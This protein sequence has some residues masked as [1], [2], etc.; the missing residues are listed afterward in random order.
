[1]KG[2]KLATMPFVLTARM[3]DDEQDACHRPP[4]PKGY[5]WLPMTTNDYQCAASK[6]WQVSL[7]HVTL[8]G[9]ILMT[10]N[11]LSEVDG[12]LQYNDE[13]WK[14]RKVSFWILCFSVFPFLFFVS[15][16]PSKKLP[17]TASC[18]CISFFFLLFIF[19][20]PGVVRAVL[21]SL[22]F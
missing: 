11:F 18:L 16:S 6:W 15:L 19:K 22:F 10:S 21:F 3:W 20:R 7:L 14:D 12:F 4:V 8:R 5:Q 13:Q 1:M 9:Q 2:D 17:L